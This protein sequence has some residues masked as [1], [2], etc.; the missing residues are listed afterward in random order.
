MEEDLHHIKDCK[1]SIVSLIIISL[2]YS[3]TSVSFKF[4]YEYHACFM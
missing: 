4:T 1:F 3:H 2:A